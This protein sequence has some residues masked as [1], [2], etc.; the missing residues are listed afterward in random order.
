M[1]L[2]IFA[3]SMGVLVAFLVGLVGESAILGFVTSINALTY[4]TFQSGNEQLVNVMFLGIT[5]LSLAV[6]VW[7]ASIMLGSSSNQGVS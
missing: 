2:T 7:V 6:A 5:I 4:I 1:E 3:L